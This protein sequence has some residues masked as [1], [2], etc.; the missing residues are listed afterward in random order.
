[1]QIITGILF[2]FL[3]S[4]AN[5]QAFKGSITFEKQTATDTISYVYHVRDNLVRIDELNKNGKVVTGTIVDIL[6]KEVKVLSPDRKLYITL[7][8]RNLAELQSEQV[9]VVKSPNAKVI[10][11]Y[12]CYQWRVKNKSKNTEFSYW[13]ASDHFF[14]FEQ[15]L[16][17]VSN[18]ERI[19]DYYLTIPDI[20]GFLP[21]VSEERTMLRDLRMCLQVKKIQKGTPDESLFKVPA[22]YAKFEK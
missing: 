21:M 2:F 18:T 9:E 14:F 1:M 13:V 12:T 15:T 7:P 16:R 6:T 3:F 11:G 17:I 10:N 22:G 4:V 20:N 19:Q 8:A 5:P